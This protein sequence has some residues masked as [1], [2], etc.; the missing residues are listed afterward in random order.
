MHPDL[1]GSFSHTSNLGELCTP[2]L[3]PVGVTLGPEHPHPPCPQL[4]APRR[5]PLIRAPGISLPQEPGIYAS[6]AAS[7]SFLIHWSEALS[8]LSEGAVH[9]SQGLSSHS[10]CPKSGQE[11]SLTSLI[12]SL[13]HCCSVQHIPCKE[14]FPT[15]TI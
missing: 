2:F 8:W 4:L 15:L 12:S 5:A 13:L 1:M 9:S 3:S 6:I 7:S 14:K 11:K 10:T